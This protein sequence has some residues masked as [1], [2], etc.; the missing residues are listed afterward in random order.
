MASD[1][2]EPRAL[3]RPV[4]P[5]VERYIPRD[6]VFPIVLAIFVGVVVWFGRS[7]HDFLLPGAN[8]LTVPAFVGQT[9]PDAEHEIARLKLKG[10]VI[11][12]AASPQYPKGVVMNQQPVPG[13]HVRAGR[14]ISLVVST[15]VQTET[16]PDLRYQSTR[17]AG[18]DLSRARLQL[19]KTTY[20]KSDDIPADHV[21]SQSPGPLVSV[22]EGTPVSIVV[23]KGGATAIKVPDF[24]GMSIDQARDQAAALHVKLGQIVWTPLGKNGPPRGRVVHQKPDAGTTISPFDVVSLDVSA[25]PHESGYLLRQAHVL[26]SVPQPQDYAPGTAL[27]VRMA[28]TDDT[29]KYNLYDGFAQPGQKLDFN[30]TTVGT[31]VV[32][33]YV[34]EVLVGETRLGHEPNN[35]YAPV[36]KP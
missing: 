7:I 23:S 27:R 19:A 34:N 2:I 18:L 8:T 13:M 24:T 4:P 6:W 16:M 12:Q 31:S 30:I 25:G 22:T 5:L 17:E 21:I 11:G 28:V 32:D 26:A 15:G 10:A 3:R 36:E 33:F 1:N 20:Q 9:L 14:Q 35:A 29:G